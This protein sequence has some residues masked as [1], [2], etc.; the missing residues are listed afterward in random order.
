MGNSFWLYVVLVNIPIADLKLLRERDRELP[1]ISTRI[2]GC[3]RHHGREPPGDFG[4]TR[5]GVHPHQAAMT[6][7]WFNAV[8]GRG[9]VRC[10]RDVPTGMHIVIPFGDHCVLAQS[11]LKKDEARAWARER[12]EMP[13]PRGR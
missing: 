11:F 6:V 5:V 13:V 8:P 12:H 4:I 3:A 1:S 7:T 2:I 9:K 10:S